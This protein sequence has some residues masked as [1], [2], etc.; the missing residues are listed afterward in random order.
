MTNG[1]A[2]V[3]TAM[4]ND[5]ATIIM[6]ETPEAPF[7]TPLEKLRATYSGHAVFARPKASVASWTKD[8]KIFDT[9]NGSGGPS[10]TSC[11]STAMWSWPR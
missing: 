1:E 3:L 5:L 4:H 10:S 6:P 9:K 2:C 8:L 11:P 7:E